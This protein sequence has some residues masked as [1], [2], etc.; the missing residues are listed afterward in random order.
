MG[1]APFQK[2]ERET[3]LTIENGVSQ[4]SDSCGIT[5]FDHIDKLVSIPS[6]TDEFVG[7]RLITVVQERNAAKV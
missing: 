1:P 5:R 3:R 4:Y 2:L 6:F 7:D